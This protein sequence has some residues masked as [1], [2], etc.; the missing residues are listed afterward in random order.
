MAQL[1]V[2]NLEDDIKDRLRDRAHQSGKSMEEEV[3]DILRAAVI[4]AMSKRPIR[5]LGAWC[6]QEFGGLK[7]GKPVDFQQKQVYRKL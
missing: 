4:P 1:I 2:R 7:L 5:D 6:T 3:R